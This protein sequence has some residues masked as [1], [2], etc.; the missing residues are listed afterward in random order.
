MN[1]NDVQKI[2]DLGLPRALLRKY[3]VMVTP[4]GV[5][6]KTTV[7]MAHFQNGKQRKMSDSGDRSGQTPTDGGQEMPADVESID[8]DQEMSSDGAM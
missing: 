3:Y 5:H 6:P 8:G 4:E 1:E 7:L 2:D